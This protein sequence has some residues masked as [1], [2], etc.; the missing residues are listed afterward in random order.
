MRG[1]LDEWTPEAR[2]RGISLQVRL[3]V[4]PLALLGDPIR[5]TQAIGN[6][7]ENALKYADS[8]GWVRVDLGPPLSGSYEVAVTDSGPGIPIEVLPFDGTTSLFRTISD[9]AAHISV[10][11]ANDRGNTKRSFEFC[12]LRLR[13][14]LMTSADTCR[15]DRPR[16]RTELSRTAG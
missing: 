10:A 7:I 15:L 5:L 11:F 14:T 9:R 4:G 16:G 1:T 3:P 12:A 13:R 8:G 2:R 6:L